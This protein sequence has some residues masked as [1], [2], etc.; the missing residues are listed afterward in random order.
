MEKTLSR[1]TIDLLAENG[2]QIRSNPERIS[3]KR[4]PGIMGPIVIMII[5]SFASIPLFA[6]GIIYGVGLIVGMLGAIIIRRIYFSDTSWF[7]ISHGKNT[8]SAKIGTYYQEDQPL[9]M[10]SG[11]VL[12]SQFID[13]YV[14]AA[15]NSVEEH[16]ITILIQLINKEEIIVFKLK[17]DQSEPGAEIN[18]LYAY[19]EDAVKMAKVA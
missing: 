12:H 2:Y 7:K 19:L 18:E 11:I 10:I 4:S 15:R 13:Q 8:F 6:A 16:L 5:T 3:F 14:T 1:K 9:K 17:S